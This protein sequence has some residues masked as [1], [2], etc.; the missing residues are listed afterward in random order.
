MATA[1]LVWAGTSKQRVK[2]QVKLE[3]EREEVSSCDDY[4]VITLG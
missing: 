2:G 1:V 4:V 3:K